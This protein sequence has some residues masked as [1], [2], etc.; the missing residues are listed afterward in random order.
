MKLSSRFIAHLSFNK[1]TT[2]R[3][4]K[5]ATVAANKTK[6][7]F[8]SLL[9]EEA[10]TQKTTVKELDDNTKVIALNRAHIMALKVSSGKEALQL[11][12]ASERLF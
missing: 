12:V 5:D 9:E 6:E 7:T 10:A 4:P 11:L 1:I 8:K 3:S 2:L